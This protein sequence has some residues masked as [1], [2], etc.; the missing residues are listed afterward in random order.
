[1]DLI[2]VSV[3][4]GRITLANADTIARPLRLT[5]D[6]ALAL[7]VALRT[8]ADLP[9]MTER[10]AVDRALAKLER[11]AGDAAAAAQRVRVALEADEEPVVGTV[12]D[13]L[14]TGRRLHLRYYVPGRDEVTERDVDPLRLLVVDGR[15]YLEAWC[16]RVDAVRLFRLD[17]VL[18][19]DALETAAAPPPAA[20]VRDLDAGL[21]AP[22]PEDIRVRLALAPAARWVAEHYPCEEVTE[23]PDGGLVVVLPVGDP[24][25]VRRLALRLGGAARV[26]EPPGLASAVAAD[27][28]AAL[29]AYGDAAAALAALEDA[30]GAVDVP[31]S[32]SSSPPAPDRP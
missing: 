9:G 20:T 16:R 32:A 17:R 30:A 1:G 25:W 26:L 14:A 12:R 8:L 22:A 3:E 2:E 28:A 23:A 10:D 11:A 18:A 29:A 15:S 7:L 31:P 19:V 4:G 5:P 21:Y 27:A 24:G 6:E 13:A